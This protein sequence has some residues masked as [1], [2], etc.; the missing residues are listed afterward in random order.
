MISKEVKLPVIK[1]VRCMPKMWV[2]G[3][4]LWGMVSAVFGSSEPSVT[5]NDV[6]MPDIEMNGDQLVTGKNYPVNVSYS[7]ECY[8]CTGS[9]LKL[10]VSD[11]AVP[12][13]NRKCTEYPVS[14]PPWEGPVIELPDTTELAKAFL[15]FQVDSQPPIFMTAGFKWS[16]WV[17]LS[18]QN[19]I[20]LQNIQNVPK[21]FYVW[22]YY[23]ARLKNNN[24]IICYADNKVGIAVE[25]KDKVRIS[26]LEDATLNDEGIYTLDNICVYSSTGEVK[27]YFNGGDIGNKNKFFQLRNSNDERIDY[28]IRVASNQNQK[29]PNTYKKDGRAGS[30]WPANDKADDCNNIPNMTFIIQA[31]KKAMNDASDGK[32]SDTMT[33][34]VEPK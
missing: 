26:G 23:Q 4:V 14:L 1:M 28:S 9:G 18:G 29:T 5:I 30:Y 13:S 31:D 6:Q 17:S 19:I 22:V 27:L 2:V 11:T 33:V 15:S 24:W 16:N 3:V 8:G 25:S 12:A 34:T 32:Y 7:I 21:V 10:T 20:T